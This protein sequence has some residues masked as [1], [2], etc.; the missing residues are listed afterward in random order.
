M[1]GQTLQFPEHIQPPYAVN[2]QTGDTEWCTFVGD[3][4]TSVQGQP[5]QCQVW[6]MPGANQDDDTSLVNYMLAENGLLHVYAG[7]PQSI[8]LMYETKQAMQ[9]QDI[10]SSPATNL[11]RML[12]V[13]NIG[14]KCAQR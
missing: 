13:L 12:H 2:S 3:G 8:G 11:H 5:F 6:R 4:V 9:G 7:Q 10:K 1:A 14:H